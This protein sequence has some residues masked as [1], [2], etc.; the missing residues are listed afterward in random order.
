MLLCRVSCHSYRR[1]PRREGIVAT[2]QL[3]LRRRQYSSTQASPLASTLLNTVILVTLFFTSLLAGPMLSG[4]CANF[5]SVMAGIA[6]VGSVVGMVAFFELLWVLERWSV[7]HAVLGMIA[8]IA[9]QR[10]VFKAMISVFLTREF[11]HDESNRAWWTGV[12]GFA[13]VTERMG[14]LLTLVSVARYS[15]GGTADL[16]AQLGRSRHESLC[17]RLLRCHCSRP[18]S[19]LA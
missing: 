2:S 1:Q 11:K 9:I 18:T 12:S 19:S 8:T 17:A 7:S 5:G 10:F 15:A 3:P 4:C 6:H 14:M 13:N 16:V